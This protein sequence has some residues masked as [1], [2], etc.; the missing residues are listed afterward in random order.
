MTGVVGCRHSS[1]FIKELL[2]MLHPTLRSATVIGLISCVAGLRAETASEQLKSA[3]IVLVEILSSS[4]K[5]IPKDLLDKAYCVVV[6]PGVKQVAFGAG[7]STAGDSYLAVTWP[8]IR[9]GRTRS[10]SNGGWQSGISNWASEMDIDM[11]VMNESGK[12]RLL[13]SKFTLGAKAGVAAGP[14]GRTASAETDAR[15]TAGI[16]SWSR[17]RG[18]F[19]GLS[20]GGATL[21]DDLDQKQL[22]GKRLSNQQI[23]RD[24]E[25]Q[26]PAAAAEF[27][28]MLNK[29]SPR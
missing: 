25:A 6:V 17:S 4:D 26:H 5:G 8:T 7:A 20:V 22:Y 13:Q 1:Q 24:K 21:R 3:T 28:L 19:A 15:L 10:C 9:V 18:V 29:Y 27:L 2:K 14:V 16:L 11:L 12:R 23:V